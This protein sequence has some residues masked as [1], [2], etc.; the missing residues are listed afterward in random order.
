MILTLRSGQEWDGDFA[1][2]TMDARNIIEGLPYS[3]SGYILNPANAIN[4][5]AYP[6]GIPLLFA[7]IYSI[8]GIDLVKLKI[9]C[10]STF[11]LFLGVFFKIARKIISPEYALALAAIVGLHPF[12]IE[13][14]NSPASEFPF[15]LFCYG[16][17]FIL[18]ALD[19]GQSRKGL[20]IL[21]AF[22]VAFSYL[23]RSIGVLLFPAAFCVSLYHSRQLFSRVNLSLAGAAA[24]VICVQ[25]AFPTDVGTYVHYFDTFSVHTVRNAINRYLDVRVSLIGRV[26]ILSPLAGVILGGAILCF[27]SFG[28]VAKARA[29]LSVYEV[30]FIIYLFFLILYPITSDVTRYA[31]P[32]WPLLFLYCAYGIREI[33]ARMQAA[34]S[35]GLAVGVAALVSILY[36]VQFSSMN[37]GH[38]PFSVEDSQSL[39]LFNAVKKDL[40]KDAAVL[41]RKPTIVALYTDHPASIWPEHFTDDELWTYME[42]LQIRYVIQDRYHLGVHERAEDV[43]DDFIER[44]RALLHPIFMNE[45]FILYKDARSSKLQRTF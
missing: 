13:S 11:V 18:N 27:A 28:I 2:Y 3:K 25:L 29:R 42:K 1:L 16:S 39:E 36:G 14:E 6:P 23:T 33:S 21:A 22:A 35:A 45:W 32:V 8:F 44:N 41:T 26:A 5:A 4:P 19:E 15:M 10:I 24:L 12:I 43:L 30:F 38:I 9:V 31:M 20:M 34:A 17:L 37:F 40:P 7:P